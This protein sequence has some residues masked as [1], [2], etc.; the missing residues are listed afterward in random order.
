MRKAFEK[1]VTDFPLSK[2]QSHIDSKDYPEF[3][4]LCKEVDNTLFHK[5]LVE[6]LALPNPGTVY[7][8]LIES[9]KGIYPLQIVTT[10]ID[11]CLE[12]SL[13]LIDVIE[14]SDFERCSESIVSGLPFIAKL[15]GTISSIEST[16]FA[17][18]DYD[19]L[20]RSRS[21]IAALRALF[22]TA[23]VVFLGYGLQDKYVLD[24]ITE[25]SDEHLLF[26][27]GPHFRVSD[28]PG[29]PQNG[30]HLI[31]YTAA[32]HQDHRAAL[33]VLNF[34]KQHR[35]TP[36]VEV[37]SVSTTA[38]AAQQESGFYLSTFTPS[39]THISGQVLE[40]T[41]PEGKD[42]INAIVGLG[43]V[44][45]ELPSSE[46][47]AFHDL[48]VGLLCF[49][50]VFLPL[51]S[52]GV[53]HERATSEVFWALL[54]S[55]AIKFIDV[56]HNPFYVA[57]PDS[58]IGDV[59]IARIQEPNQNETRSSMSVVRAMLTPVT[60][61]EKQAETLIEG[62]E[63]KIRQFDASQHLNLAG[64]VRDS[65][66]MPRVSQLLGFSEYITTGR[67][68]RWLAYPTLRFAHLVQTGLICNQLKIRAA[69]IPFGGELL[70]SAAFNVR[71]AE[72]TVYEYASF[73]M[74]GAFGSNLSYYL[75]RNPRVLLDLLKF[76][77]SPEG[78]ALRGEISDRLKTNDGAEFASAIDGG[79]RRAVSAPV[80]QAAR[81]KYSELMKADGR[82][83]LIEAIWGDSNT[84]DGSLH[85]WRNR[86]RE[87]LLEEAK[88]RG[89]RN[90]SPCLCGSGDSLGDCCLR[91]LR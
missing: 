46:S 73:V 74:A 76:R 80:L 48:A 58:V 23:S 15:H 3:F 55:D 54:A 88:S 77:E 64:M 62:L 87:L 70:L 9:L 36:S 8:Q 2:A 24:L 60:G 83:P 63:S 90:D 40:L 17:R 37:L 5:T 18:S 50:R 33:T 53:L 68:P 44:Q 79:L 56:V 84:G 20:I 65:L 30:V 82:G 22:S 7:A 21:Y 45:W 11:R 25:N 89:I 71:P 72:N 27:S 14:R 16:V 31:G 10:N 6:L 41:K 42:K 86:S 26:G 67:I 78:E 34:I 66:L 47:V 32:H 1:G 52:L 51:A 59:G 38:D 28:T 81:N 12:Q 35:E 85:L 39:G 19:Q 69:R 61:M 75:E 29:E 49:D 57:R 43:F 4:Q 91:V 13:G